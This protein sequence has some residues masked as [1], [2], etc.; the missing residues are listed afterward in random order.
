M[1]RLFIIK[2]KEKKKPKFE[3]KHFIAIG[4]F[5]VFIFASIF[6]L[7]LNSSI[8]DDYDEDYTDIGYE[9]PSDDEKDDASKDTTK[10]D[11]LEWDFL[12][13]EPIIWIFVGTM[14]FITWWV[15]SKRLWRF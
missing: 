10:D 12:L 9:V 7:I 5:V 15:L 14:M 4:I 6:F 3:K 1:A 13:S 8:D 11:E 2:Q